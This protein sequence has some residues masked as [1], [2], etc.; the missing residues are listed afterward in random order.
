MA[1]DKT[2]SIPTI[3]K[4]VGGGVLRVGS[5]LIQ[6]I[7]TSGYWVNSKI[8]A[9]SDEGKTTFA[10]SKFD[11]KVIPKIQCKLLV[12]RLFDMLIRGEMELSA[13]TGRAKKHTF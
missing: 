5:A 2:S 13:Y 8:E 3:G 11:K 4:K 6:G 7:N 9:I 1:T 12:A 10:D